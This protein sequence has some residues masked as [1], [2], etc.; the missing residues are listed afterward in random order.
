MQLSYVLPFDRNVTWSFEASGAAEDWLESFAGAMGIAPGEGSANRCIHFEI[1]PRRPGDF[2]GRHL[3]QCA[4]D[5]SREKWKL[6]EFPDMIFFQ[7]PAHCEII[8]EIAPVV[9]RPGRAHQMRR[10]LLP[11]YIEALH[12]GGLPVHGALVEIDGCGVIL[13]GRSGAGKSTACRRLPP[14]WRVLGDDLCLVMP[15]F[16]GGYRAHP[17]PTWSAFIEN[18]GVCQSV[19]SVP[20]RAVFFLGQS[21]EDQCL[22]LKKNT[23]AISMAGAAIEVFQSIDFGFPHGEEPAVKKDLYANASSMASKIPACLFRLS[24]TGR[25]WERIEEALGRNEPMMKWRKPC[26]SERITDRP[27]AMKQKE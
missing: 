21:H 12:S 1:M 9:D 6:R 13:A 5:L 10:A 18:G 27:A 19:S 15:D 25:F 8:C 16:S 7:H 3:R 20:L 17:L 2:F 23:A 24:L 14:P 26:N 11:V 22:D 4:K